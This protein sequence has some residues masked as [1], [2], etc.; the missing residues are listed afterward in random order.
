LNLERLQSVAVIG[1]AGKMGSGIAWVL[2]QAM[3]RADARKHGAPGS[4]EY[5]LTLVDPAREGFRRLR[6]Y[7][8]G[9]LVKTGEKRISELREWAR[10][11]KDLVENGEIIEAWVD[12][13]LSMLRFDTDPGAAHGAR[14]V[15]EAVFE[16]RDVKRDLYRRLA[17][18]CAP[19]AWYFTNTSSIPIAA[20]AGDAGLEGRLIGY[21]FYNPPAV[22][23][24]VEV[25]TSP[26]TDPELAAFAAGLGP[27]LE[28]TL[29]PSRDVAGF[30][31]NGHF[32]RE[33]L[34][35]LEQA[36][37]LMAEWPAPE[38][39]FLVNKV[40]QDYLV[41]PMGIF[42]LLDYV[43]WDV[44]RM[45]LEVMGEHLP[46]ESFRSDLGDVLFAAGIRGGQAGSGEQKDGLFKYGKNRMTAIF[47]PA[48]G[49]HVPLT[50][51]RFGRAADWLGPLPAEHS[52]WNVLSRDPAKSDRLRKYFDALSKADTRGGRL[53]GT[54]LEHGSEVAG[55]LVGTGVA[56]S[57]EDVKKVLM[58][59]FFH[60]YGPM[61]WKQG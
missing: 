4:G 36:Q 61:D 15:F 22:Q 56:A 31:G 19:D 42:Q 29:V 28:K 12:G 51:P 40:T 32:I 39:F 10:N 27:V 52:P 60:L 50:D 21:H 17:R 23:K 45:I 55:K 49:S 46:G 2:L 58:L 47:D 9:Q 38:A 57:G 13:A 6:D 43:G 18:V 24:L 5:E 3:A 30:I 26:G 7:L 20:L 44:F 14:L 37:A 48:S 53:A 11:R 33:G 8:K 1:A 41:R 25:I 54:F 16:R 34:F 35:A 59:G